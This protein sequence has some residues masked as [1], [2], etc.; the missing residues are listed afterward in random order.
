MGRLQ[1]IPEILE[2]IGKGDNIAWAESCG[3]VIIEYLI[4]L[5]KTGLEQVKQL[6][7][8]KE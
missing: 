8:H 2:L 3:F 5:L 1:I 4:A 6:F 7:F